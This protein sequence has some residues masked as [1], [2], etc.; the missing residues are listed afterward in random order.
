MPSTMTMTMTL[1][2][3]QWLP[4]S[5][6]SSSGFGR[7]RRLASP[8]LPSCGAPSP[9][10]GKLT[11]LLDLGAFASDGRKR[12]LGP[13]VAPTPRSPP[14]AAPPCQARRFQLR[15]GQILL[16]SRCL[17]ND[18]ARARNGGSRLQP[19]RPNFKPLSLAKSA[20][21]PALLARAAPLA[22]FGACE[23]AW[24]SELVPKTPRTLRGAVRK[25]SK[26]MMNYPDL[27]VP[28]PLPASP[29]R[30]RS[31]ASCPPPASV[32]GT[33]K[34][35]KRVT[36]ADEHG[37]EKA[38]V[39]DARSEQ[40]IREAGRKRG[41][42]MLEALNELRR[43][44]D[45]RRAAPLI[46]EPGI[47]P[48]ASSAAV[49]PTA[50]SP[51]AALVEVPAVD[52]EA[53]TSPLTEAEVDEPLFYATLGDVDDTEASL[54]RTE[55]AL[56]QAH[57]PVGEYGATR[58][59]TAIISARTLAVV[60]R[61]IALVKACEDRLAAFEAAQ[62]QKA[63][64][65]QH[66]LHDTAP[67][68]SELL[69]INKFIQTKVHKGGSPLEANKSDF[70]AFVSSFGLPENHHL[71]RRLNEVGSAATDWWAQTALQEAQADADTAAVSRMLDLAATIL[72]NKDHEAIVTCREVLG[73]VLAE[74]AL[75][76]AKKIKAKDAA[77]VASNPRPQPESAK[78]SQ[79]AINLEIKT[80]VAM[81]APTSHPALLEAKNIATD[82]QIEEKD[83]WAQTVLVFAEEQMAKDEAAA[84]K[85][86]GVPPVGP[87]SNMADAIEREIERV[88]KERSVPEAHP[89]LKEALQ[90]S[91]ELRTKDGDRKRMFARERR[92][93]AKKQS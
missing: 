21:E 46:G 92:L 8:A 83:R 47:L 34:S 39:P 41:K 65:R 61:K 91:K 93:A 35:G 29:S 42:Q 26:T 4:T 3:R 84:A 74:N 30:P 77:R 13:S 28:P 55:A 56:S 49:P 16:P 7:A 2:E 60:R 57:E 59:A 82:L 17:S 64:I 71:V 24:T 85:C 10:A 20:S 86:S 54:R 88:V 50:D 70:S 68:P 6:S 72:G 87:A 89:V 22:V 73:N 76:N 31:P 32:R 11:Q 25:A 75:R 12:G 23:P 37:Y 15:P 14:E 33:P 5:P 90:V 40:A 79:E 9:G 48:A 45:F 78:S 52:A 80:A 69:R 27:P 1:S 58:H 38:A 43:A 63:E 53:A 44:G 51:A 62:A 66:L 18:P 81:G 19:Q 36:F 67:A